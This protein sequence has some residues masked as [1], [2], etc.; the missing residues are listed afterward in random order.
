M[1]L[2]SIALALRQQFAGLAAYS[3]SLLLDFTTG[4]QTL[5]P[6]ITFTRASNATV[7]GP[8]GTLQYAPHNLLTF[9]EQFDNSSVVKV[10]LNVAANTATA[11]DGTMTADVVSRSADG[12]ANR[13]TRFN[14]TTTQTGTYTFSQYCKPDGATN[15]VALRLQDSAAV[16]GHCLFELVGDGSVFSSSGAVGTIEKQG[17]WY[18]VSV[19]VSLTGTF[20][21]I[22]CLTFLG[23]YGTSTDPTPFSFWGAQL[24]VGALQPYYPTTVKNLLGFTQE[25]DNAAWTK[26][27]SSIDAIKVIAPDGSVTGQKL[28]ENTDNNTHILSRVI[29]TTAAPHT[30]SFYAKASERSFV[31]GL[32]FDGTSFYT[33]YFD[34]TTGVVGTLS[35]VGTAATITNAGNGWFRCSITATTAASGASQFVVRT[36]TA[37][38][39]DSYTGDGTSGIFIWG[40]QLSDSASLDPYVYNP[41]AAPAAAAYYGPRFDYDPVTL[42]P[43]GLL[44]EEARTNLSTNSV[45]AS[46][47]GAASNASYVDAQALAPDGTNTAWLLREDTA[48]AV[49]FGSMVSITHSYVSGTT[50]TVS[51]FLKASGRT[52]VSVYLPAGAFASN[53]RVAVFDLS[54]G[55][56][57]STETGVT[58]SIQNFG[59]GWYRCATTAT[60]NA[61]IIAHAGGSALGGG[62]AYLGNGTS[63]AFVWGHQ[64]ETASFSTSYIPTTTAAVTR[65]ADVAVMTGANFSNWYNATTGAVFVDYATMQQTGF[66]SIVSASDGTNT[67]RIQLSHVSAARRAVVTAG[68]ASQWDTQGGNLGSTTS[69][70]FAKYALAYEASNYAAAVNGGTPATQ[71][72]GSV[73]TGLS[74]LSVGADG[75]GV[76]YINGHIRRLA[77]FPRRLTNAELQA[78][79]S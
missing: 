33:A 42:A 62:A 27:R 66:P 7:T 36:A 67:N 40:A 10:G 49:H 24:N 4:N 69:G 56:V 53:G 2:S 78:I 76:S 26:V 48:N 39:T 19:T 63:G 13:N 59:N 45:L 38:G 73:P 71:L 55:T 16:G 68:G 52:L 54:S 21:A 18:R 12:T 77:Y 75:A 61:S 11:P 17:D 8:D 51:R 28:V 50:Y 47:W 74:R 35:G 43:R 25:F 31:R 32:L 20:T 9:S 34:L 41:G 79:T 14:L 22:Q 3:P 5:D 72:S 6:R 60:A 64:L 23:A 58:A 57:V 15:R 46:A 44:I 29:T 70:V 30:L 37:N 1:Q 65:A